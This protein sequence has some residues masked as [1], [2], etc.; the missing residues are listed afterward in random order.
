M[1][2]HCCQYS[3]V[4]VFSWG[5]WA[6]LAQAAAQWFSRNP[7]YH[8]LSMSVKINVVVSHF[9]LKISSCTCPLYAHWWSC[10]VLRVSHSLKRQMVVNC[11][12]AQELPCPARVTAMTLGGSHDRITLLMMLT[13]LLNYHERLVYWHNLLW[14]KG[15]VMHYWLACHD[16][17]KESML[18]SLERQSVTTSS[19]WEHPNFWSHAFQTLNSLFHK[20]RVNYTASS[21]ITDLVE[22]LSFWK[23]QWIIF[24]TGYFLFKW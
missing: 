13:I 15:N 18:L 6:W 20:F 16:N 24:Y 23:L 17:N 11:H 12:R 10:L 7:F 9:F 3:F 5:S 21:L 8:S 2:Y 4:L 19:L 14:P 1:N 22:T